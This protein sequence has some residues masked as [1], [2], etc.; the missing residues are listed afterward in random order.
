MGEDRVADGSAWIRT[1]V[2]SLDRSSRF[3]YTERN[4]PMKRAIDCPAAY[5]YS[6]V[7]FD[8]YP[9]RTNWDFLLN[10]DG[11][12]NKLIVAEFDRAQG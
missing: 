5:S 6:T 1:P 10:D 4:P 7:V 11:V 3:L 8:V 9:E 2:K 12:Q